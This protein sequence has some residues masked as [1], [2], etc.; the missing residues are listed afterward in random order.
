MEKVY[1]YPVMWQ[2]VIDSLKL[3][4]R[5]VIIDCTAGLGS[6]AYKMIQASEK[7]SFLIGLDKDSQ[8]LKEAYWKLKPF[9][10]RF[11]LLQ[12]DFINLDKVCQ[13]FDIKKADVFFFDLGIST[14]QLT[15][16]Q[17]G[18]SFLSEGALDMRINKDNF[19]TAFDL[20]NNLSE[21]ELVK[22]FKKFGE[23]R[24]SRRIA[25]AAVTHR[26]KSLISTTTQL[27]EIIEKSVPVKSRFGRIHPATRVFQALRIAVNRELEA[28]KI[29]LPKAIN[30]LKKGGRIGVISFHSLEDRIVKHTFKNFA[31]QNLL[32]IITKKP[33]RPTEEEKRINSASRS[34]KL[35]I[36]EKIG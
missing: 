5:E 12:E 36:A 16:P 22:I 29:A 13:E 8:S 1:H 35:R 31:S 27:A 7:N 26:Q 14:Y 18:F 4:D 11:V 9:E 6:H 25:H 17:R 10:G 34:A 20:V 19:L 21:R 15:N 3:I 32:K 2:E 28:L 23:E 30:L 24:Y 33:K